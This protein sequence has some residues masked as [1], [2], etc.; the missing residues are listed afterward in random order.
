M[1][2]KLVVKLLPWTVGS[3]EL[4]SYFSKFG[5]VTRSMV[6]FDKD[7]GL[8]KGIGFVHLKKG[9][10]FQSLNEYSDHVIDGKKIEVSEK[11]Y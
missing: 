7:T 3:R 4:R 8:S 5:Y 2:T 11:R 6:V 1:S 9:E 10:N